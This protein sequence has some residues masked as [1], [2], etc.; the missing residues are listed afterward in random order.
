MGID[1]SIGDLILISR[2]CARLG[3]P[4][5]SRA[6]TRAIVSSGEEK[7]RPR[8]A[9]GG[10]KEDERSRKKGEGERTQGARVHIFHS[11][12]HV[13]ND[14]EISARLSP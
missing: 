3:D 2:N 10:R 8:Q 12:I 4:L 9:K 14:S 5:L 11:R 13:N 1:R 6:C 7:L